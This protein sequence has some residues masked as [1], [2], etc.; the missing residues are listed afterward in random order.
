MANPERAEPLL[1]FAHFLSVPGVGRV[2]AVVVGRHDPGRDSEA[3]GLSAYEGAE[4]VVRRAVRAACALGRTFEGEVILAPDVTAALAR[5]SAERHP[6]TVLLGMSDMSS[7]TGVEV[8]EQVLEGTTGDVVVLN[9]PPDFALSDVRRVLVPVAGRA[10]HDP[11]RARLLGMLL[12]EGERGATLLRILRPGEERPLAERDLLRRAEDLGLGPDSCV[13]ETSLEPVEVILDHSAEA[14]LL[15]LGFGQGARRRRM[16]G[17]FVLR[18][19]GGARCPVVAITEA[20]PS[21]LSL[22][23]RSPASRSH[24]ES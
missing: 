1:R 15:V 21:R 7:P 2:H 22:S 9:A 8:L 6:E 11:L 16:V 3:D 4:A 12:R 18:V 23:G 24:P 10:P 5:V 14:D 20:Q 19:V 13:V 17:P